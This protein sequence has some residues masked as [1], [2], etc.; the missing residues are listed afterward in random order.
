MRRL[1]PLF[2][3]A[4]IAGVGVYIGRQRDAQR[5]QLSGFFESQPISVSSRTAGRV[6][7]ISAV[8]GATVKAGELLLELDAA[9]ARAEADALEA[10]AQQVQARFRELKAGP[11]QEDVRRQ[12]AVVR[13][14][15]AQLE[16]V[17]NGSRQSEI[18]AA[19]ARYEE[20][21]A[22]Y[23]RAQNGS[24]REDVA[25]L[26]AALEETRARLRFAGAELKRQE[27]LYENE[28]ISRQT[29]D[30]ARQDYE[31]ALAAARQAEQAHLLSRRGS[32]SED[33]S[34]ARAAMDAAEAQYRQVAEGS[35]PEDVAA[36][37]ARVDQAQ[38]QLDSLLAGTRSEELEQ[39]AAALR[40][41]RMSAR[42]RRENVEEFKVRAPRAGR[43]ERVLVAAGD[44]VQANAPLIRMADPNDLWL[45]VYL[46][47]DKL[48]LVSVGD[49]A[50]IH[51][52]G[53]ASPVDGIVESI[54]TQG[55]FTPAN[56][57]T[58]EDRGR[59]VFAVRLR[60][61]KPQPAVKAGMFATVRRIGRWP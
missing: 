51:V 40:S 8:E 58:P 16:R 55:E 56:L 48:A 11:R 31:V 4:L 59:Q 44:L 60:L 61:A 57:Q 22:A 30:K 32:R 46:P 1:L 36:A 39:A 41:A 20:A 6:L 21:R 19:R 23:E 37:Q 50:L 9:P 26:E 13:E 34:A 25:R 2:L 5:S 24:R 28:A 15:Q 7:R 17:R 43:V 27:F 29:F 42:S 12:Q 52:D 45:R 18:D 54:A 49:A 38:A 3:V 47:E 14:L 10:Q 53:F 33:I 35:R